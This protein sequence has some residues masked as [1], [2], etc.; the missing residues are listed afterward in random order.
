MTNDHI[1]T[2]QRVSVI[3]LGAM[4]SGIARTLLEGGFQV[5]VWNRSHDKME[6]MAALGA[7]ACRTPNEAIQDS[8]QIV[9][10]LTAYD[11]WKKKPSRLVES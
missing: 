1:G 11:V 4:G 5:S 10:C 8:T 7:S 2:D 6:A 9:I 3:G